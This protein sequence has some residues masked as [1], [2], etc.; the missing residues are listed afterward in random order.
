MNNKMEY[1]EIV[2]CKVTESRSVVV[3]ECS[4]GGY[5]IAQRLEAKDGERDM[6]VFLKGAFHINDVEGLMHLRDTI[7]LAIDKVIGK[8]QPEPSEN[9]DDAWE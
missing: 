6:P 9:D 4:K 1:T 2:A 5:T 8:D 7:N 3:S